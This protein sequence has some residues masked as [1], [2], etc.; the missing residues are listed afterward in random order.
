MIQ[1][2]RLRQPFARTLAAALVLF[3]C[4]PGLLKPLPAHAQERAVAKPRPALVV[5]VARPERAG[6]P[7]RLAANGSIAAWQEASVGAEIGGL[8]LADLPVAVG[9]VVRQGQML[10]RFAPDL[11]EADLAVAEASAAQARASLA[12]ARANA[13]RARE[14]KDSGALSAQQVSQ[15]LSAETIAVAQLQ[16]AQAQVLQQRLRLAR[17]R[18]LAPDDGIVSAR[19]ATL[20]AVVPQGQELFRMVLRNRLEWR[21]EVTAEELGRIRPGQGVE[22][23]AATGERLKGRVRMVGPTVDPQTRQGLVY[24]DLPAAAT[25]RP[26]MFARGEF[27]FGA[28][29][30]LTLPQAAVVVRDGFNLVFE[31]GADDKVTQ[32]KVRIGRRM[33]ERIEIVAGLEPQA[34]VVVAGAGFLNDG[35]RVSVTPDAR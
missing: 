15:Y 22:V 33:G 5:K 6:W 14:V 2:P 27:V 32:R 4:T 25:A 9:D 1:P 11:V 35:D 12:E 26:G 18:V 19:P 13:E 8:R 29:T 7:E 28:A 24:V 3:A 17:T 34:R 31:L 20:G 21:A 16:V 30:A 10:A 23:V